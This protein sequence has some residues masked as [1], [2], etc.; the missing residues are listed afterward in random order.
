M[1]QAN[2]GLIENVQDKGIRNMDRLTYKSCMGDYG[3]AKEFL[4]EYEEKCV[5]RNALGKI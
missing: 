1:Q 3:S 5:L 2:Y 4:N